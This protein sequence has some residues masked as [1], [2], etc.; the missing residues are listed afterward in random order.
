MKWFG[1]LTKSASRPRSDFENEDIVLF[2]GSRLLIA[3]YCVSKKFPPLNSLLLCQTLTDFQKFC[4]AAKRMKFATKSV[5]HYP[6][7]LVATLPWKIKNSNF[8]HI[9]SKHGK[10]MQTNCILIASNF[11]IHPQ[12]LIFSVFKIVSLSPYW[13]QIKFSMSL[14]FYLITFAINLWHWKFFTAD[15]TAVFVNNQ[16]GIQRQRQDFDN[17]F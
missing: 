16:H 13:L 3:L 12:I 15:I 7:H 17:K 5:Q 14:F 9:F 11:V 4:T 8:L 6:P 10:K 1:R 2:Q